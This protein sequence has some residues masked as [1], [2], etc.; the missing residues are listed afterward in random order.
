MRKR[1][2]ADLASWRNNREN[3][4]TLEIENDLIGRAA[5]DALVTRSGL[6][7]R[8][9]IAVCGGAGE[10]A[11]ACGRRDRYQSK[12]LS[13]S[14]LPYILSLMHTYFLRRTPPQ[15]SANTQILHADINYSVCSGCLCRTPVV[16]TLFGRIMPRGNYYTETPKPIELR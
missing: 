10:R 14:S 6:R 13:S 9:G 7:V 1:R 3:I 4:R 8:G 15:Q 12:T 16:R 2:S 11:A 5:A